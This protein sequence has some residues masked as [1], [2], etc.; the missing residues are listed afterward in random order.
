MKSSKGVRMMT[1]IAMLVTIA[2]VLDILAGLIPSPFVYGGSIS[3]AM[4][5]IFVLAYRHDWKVGLLSGLA[6][7]LLS[8]MINPYIVHPIQYVLDYMVAF[9]VLGFAGVF[10]NGLTRLDHFVYGIIL[11]SL[12]RYGAH[13]LS[14]VVFFSDVAMAEG[15]HPWVYSFIIYNLPYMVASMA[16]SLIIGIVLWKR[17]I[18]QIGKE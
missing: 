17:H 18:L 9:T 2:L 3:L 8:S 14:G 7:G 6:F 11:G 1:E 4:L 10:R 12:L 15:Y 16:L 5:P 13:G